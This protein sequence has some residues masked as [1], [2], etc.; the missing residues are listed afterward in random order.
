MLAVPVLAGSSAFAIGETF[1]LHVGLARRLKRAPTFYGVIAIAFLV[2]V[3][4][5]FVH[6]DPIKAL[7]WSAVINGV[8]AVPV[9]VMM[10]LLS[11]RKAVMGPFV[12]PMALK[13]LGW[14]ATAVMA[15]AAISRDVRHLGV[16]RMML[17]ASEFRS[18]SCPAGS[19]FVSGA[20][21]TKT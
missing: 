11:S 4:L 5:N 9:M 1:G 19:R 3:G 14:L 16:V 18:S 7:F 10:M 8:V 13:V 6:I 20:V 17:H 21:D 2:G 15:L 12:L